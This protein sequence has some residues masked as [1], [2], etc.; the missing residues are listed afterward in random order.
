VLN[1]LEP[2]LED[3]TGSGEDYVRGAMMY[4]IVSEAGDAGAFSMLG[5]CYEHGRCV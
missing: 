3:C 2:Y 5:A 1:A 4:E